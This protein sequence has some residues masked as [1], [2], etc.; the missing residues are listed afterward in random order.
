LIGD[1]VF[2]YVYA[3]DDA[4]QEARAGGVKSRPSVVAR[5]GTELVLSAGQYDLRLED[6]RIPGSDQWLRGVEVIPGKR[7]ELEATF[8]ADGA[9][10]S[11]SKQ[12]AH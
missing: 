12:N 2:L 10:R 5:S 6:T 1:D 8:G 3:A 7:I 4:V 11:V 9:S